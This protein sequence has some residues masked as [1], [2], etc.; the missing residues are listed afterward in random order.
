MTLVRSPVLDGF[1]C[2]RCG[3]LVVGARVLCA[4]GRTCSAEDA[5]ALVQFLNIEHSCLPQELVESDTP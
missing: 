4:W 3:T 2:E 5:E 1:V